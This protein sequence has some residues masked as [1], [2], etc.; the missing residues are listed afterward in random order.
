MNTQEIERCLPGNVMIPYA[1]TSNHSSGGL[2]KLRFTV[3]S[4]D[5]LLTF[6]RKRMSSPAEGVCDCIIF[7]CCPM[8]KP[9]EHW[10]VLIIDDSRHHLTWQF[11]DP[12][13]RDVSDYSQTLWELLL[14]YPCLW[15]NEK[16]VQSLL[17]IM[18]GEHCLLFIYGY[19]KFRIVSGEFT[20]YKV[21]NKQTINECEEIA[22]HFK[23]KLDELKNKI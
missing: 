5:Q 2:R 10:L 4:L 6:I 8:S 17:S 23:N 11:F 20:V 14:P 12:L 9:G 7:N 15:R 16:R 22:F 19:K 13:A 3:S 21:Y 18:C 1:Q